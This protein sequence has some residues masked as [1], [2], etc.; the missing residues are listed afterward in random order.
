MLAVPNAALRF[1]PPASAFGSASARAGAGRP[2]GSA[3]TAGSGRAHGG[4]PGT[5]AG[6]DEVERKTAYKLAGLTPVAVRL[7]TGITDG[8]FTEL[9]GDTV[10]EGD[11]LIVE[12]PPSDA[13]GTSAPGA[14]QGQGQGQRAGSGSPPRVRGLF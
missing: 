14:G 1:K 4:A 8:S 2:A 5:G 10:K 3:W 13:G 6:G 11:Q 12:G 7:T 9:L